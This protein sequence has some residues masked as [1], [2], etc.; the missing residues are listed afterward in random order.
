[1]RGDLC[2]PCPKTLLAVKVSISPPGGYFLVTRISRLTALLSSDQTP[3]H[4]EGSSTPMGLSCSPCTYCHSPVLAVNNVDV[5]EPILLHLSSDGVHISQDGSKYSMIM[6][7]LIVMRF[8]KLGAGRQ[9]SENTKLRLV[10]EKIGY[11]KVF[12]LPEY[13]G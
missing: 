7:I 4:I 12:I 3:S 2:R 1:M 8:V 6:A 9:I 10:K 11:K 5:R 13:S